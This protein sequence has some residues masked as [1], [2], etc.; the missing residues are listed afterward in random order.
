MQTPPSSRLVSCHFICLQDM[1]PDLVFF[2]LFISISCVTCWSDNGRRHQYDYCVLGAGPAGLQMGYFL[3][4]ARRDYI[5]LERS[6]GP[7]SFFHRSAQDSCVN[8]MEMVVL[9]LSDLVCVCVCLQFPPTQ[10][11]DQYQQDPHR[12]SKQRVQPAS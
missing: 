8:P 9:Y 12:I 10:K 7:G 5:I 4:R 3:S 6:S 1:G 2:L 11:V